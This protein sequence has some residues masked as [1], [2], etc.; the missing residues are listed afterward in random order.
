MKTIVAGKYVYSSY[1]FS[2]FLNLQI[3]AM[4]IDNWQVFHQ[5]HTFYMQYYCIARN[6]PCKS[7]VKIRLTS[8]TLSEPN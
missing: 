1:F 4:E 5:K 6:R 2:K 3:L 8:Q 7:R